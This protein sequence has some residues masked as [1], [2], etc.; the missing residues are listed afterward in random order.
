MTDQKECAGCGK[1]FTRRYGVSAKVFAG[2]RYCSKSCSARASIQSRTK[3][4]RPVETKVCVICGKTFP[5]TSAMGALNWSRRTCCS[6]SCGIKAGW[7]NRDPNRIK[8][9]RQLDRKCEC[10]EAATELVWIIQGTA[11]GK[12]QR[13]CVEV[14][15]DCRDMW[16][17]DG[18]TLEPPEVER[19]EPR[20]YPPEY[21]ALGHW[22]HKHREF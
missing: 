4:E 1:T 22:H 14:C 13:Q 3:A 17:E 6:Q 12:R 9:M 19:D 20:Q 7:L 10:G 16:L 11:E 8:G 18:A 21:H 2:Q 5:R 15:A